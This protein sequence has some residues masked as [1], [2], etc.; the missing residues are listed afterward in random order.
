MEDGKQG[1]CVHGSTLSG[2]ALGFQSHVPDAFPCEKRLLMK[3]ILDLTLLQPPGPGY[4]MHT[5]S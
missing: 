2:R 1:A 3:G 4:A 5:G